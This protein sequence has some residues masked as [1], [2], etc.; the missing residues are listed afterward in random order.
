MGQRARARA[1]WPQDHASSLRI[2]LGLASGRSAAVI[3][4]EMIEHGIAP[5]RWSE[6]AAFFATG[7]VTDRKKSRAVATGGGAS[8]R[9]G[10]RD[11]S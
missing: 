6:I 4:D 3:R 5:T 11:M 7:S 2:A 1:N 8:H 10:F 9:R